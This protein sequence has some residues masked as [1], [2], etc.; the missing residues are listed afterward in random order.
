MVG[1]NISVL[2]YRS[3]LNDRDYSYMIWDIDN[4]P[5][6]IVGTK[7]RLQHEKKVEQELENWLSFSHN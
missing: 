1:G 4:S 3:T 6:E 5:H 7:V 2:V